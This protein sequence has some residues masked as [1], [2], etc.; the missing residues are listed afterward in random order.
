MILYLSSSLDKQCIKFLAL[1]DM[2]HFYDWPFYVCILH[3]TYI[4]SLHFNFWLI[5]ISL[6]FNLWFIFLQLY[7]FRWIFI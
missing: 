2:F 5:F 3:E 1:F 7:S 6:H 4:I